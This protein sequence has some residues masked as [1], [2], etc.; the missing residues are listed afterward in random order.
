MLGICD[1]ATVV[2]PNEELATLAETSGWPILRPARPWKSPAEKI[3][4]VLA[5]L[6]ALGKNPAKL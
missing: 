1:G 6:L 2:N 5:L 4:R 3:L